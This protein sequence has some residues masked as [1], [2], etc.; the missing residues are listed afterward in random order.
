[1]GVWATGGGGGSGGWVAGTVFAI[2]IIIMN[3]VISP[4]INPTMYFQV[5][6][7]GGGTFIY[8]TL[9]CLCGHKRNRWSRYRCWCILCI[10]G[11]IRGG[12]IRH[13]VRGNSHGTL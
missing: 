8:Y 2:I 7:E 10:D 9:R 5:Y 4:I 11:K 1:M 12:A 13:S 6:E 3:A